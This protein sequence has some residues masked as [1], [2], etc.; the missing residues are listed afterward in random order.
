MLIQQTRH[1][2]DNDENDAEQEVTILIRKEA[3][4]SEHA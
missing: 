1:G 3:G 2:W 4:R